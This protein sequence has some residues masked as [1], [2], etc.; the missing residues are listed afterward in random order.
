MEVY[1]LTEWKL[2]LIPVSWRVEP[3][4]CILMFEG[5]PSCGTPFLG[6][7]YRLRFEILYSLL[8]FPC[9][10]LYAQIVL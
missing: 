3:N 1:M 4:P 10:L 6:C 9:L 7:V 2:M 8:Y 5:T